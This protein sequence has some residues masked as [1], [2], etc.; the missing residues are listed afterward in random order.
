[1]NLLVPATKTTVK[2]TKMTDPI[3][4]LHFADVHIGMENYGRTDPN[5]GVSSRVVDF[6][7]RMDDM[8]AY[9]EDHDVDLVIFAGD[10]FKT[11]SPNQ[12]YQRE[13]A[14]RIRDLSAIAPTVL[15]VGNHDLPIN[16]LKASTIEIYS[17]LDVPNVW[18]AQDYEVQRIP[19]KR[20]DVIVGSAPYPI[21]ARIMSDINTRGMTV[22]QQDAELQKILHQL[23]EDLAVQ[24]DE[25]GG[26][27]T[28]RILTGHFT[29]AGAIWGSERSV[30]LGRDVQVDLSVLAD[31]RWDYVAL[32]HVHK[33]QNLTRDR[34]EVP[35]VV[36]SGSL[37][38][39]DFG[40]EGDVKGFCWLNLQRNQTE[41]EFIEVEA[42][43]MVTLRV[44]CRTVSNP[45]Q[46]VLDH[47]KRHLL[48]DAVVRLIIQ[49]TPETDNLLKEGTIFDAL[50]RA[51]VFHVA[52]IRKE[53]ERSDR[54]RLD[55]SPEGLTPLELLD[56]YFKSRD[57]GSARRAEL[58][59]KAKD[60]IEP[61]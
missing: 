15:L 37:E 60:I 43:P 11:R 46:K 32:G 42:R 16:V 49:L 38:R 44:D 47:M 20:G 51:G 50:K 35:S 45:T 48:V 5:S 56:R 29:V 13:F 30:M 34:D 59:E 39:I 19:T 17:T 21:R 33:H 28:P 53:V 4:V 27:D 18:V 54:S 61:K 26:A 10:A 57:I 2:T 31:T 55:V 3:R 7:R 6:L 40:E 8:V 25:Q 36:Y 58:L 41:W 22:A 52:G 12:T 9:A 14:H 1:M 23:L 24:A